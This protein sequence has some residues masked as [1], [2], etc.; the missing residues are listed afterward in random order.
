MQLH[1]YPSRGEETVHG[2]DLSRAY[3]VAA[4]LEA[5]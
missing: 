3:V 2:Y 5:L 4:L 1:S